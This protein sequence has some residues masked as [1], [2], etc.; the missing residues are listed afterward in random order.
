MLSD[1]SVKFIEI[2]PRI[3]GGT[4]LG[5]AS[6]ESW[7]TLIVNNII[8]GE[9]IEPKLIQYGLEMRRYYAEIFIP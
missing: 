7:I 1:G 3:A 6:T 8:G 2:N 9:P 5:F 4:A